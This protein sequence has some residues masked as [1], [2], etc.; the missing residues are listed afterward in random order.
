MHVLYYVRECYIYLI[1]LYTTLITSILRDSLGG[2]CKTTMIATI[3]PEAVH[4]DESISTC[5]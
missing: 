5:R 1:I 2:N 4:A 3:N